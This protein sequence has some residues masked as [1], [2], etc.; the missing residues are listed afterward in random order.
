MSSDVLA[1]LRNG[2]P[3]TRSFF[4]G[5]A[6]ESDLDSIPL[7]D[8][9]YRV[10]LAAPTRRRAARA[11]PWETIAQQPWDR[12]ARAELAPPARH[13]P[14]RR[15]RAAPGADHLEADSES[16][17]NDLVESGVGVKPRSATRSR[18]NRSRL[19]DAPSPGRAGRSR[20][21]SGSCTPPIAGRIR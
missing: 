11:A 6:P 20:P 1:R 9:V 15:R 5:A 12:G 10:T 19:V 4:F 21:S 3:T 8:V 16:V 17:I 18:R 7:R 2:T 14:L 13:G